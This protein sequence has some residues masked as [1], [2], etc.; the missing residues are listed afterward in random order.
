MIYNLDL[1]A[2]TLSILSSFIKPRLVN[3][4]KSFTFKFFGKLLKLFTSYFGNDCAT[5]NNDLYR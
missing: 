4:F 2:N 5:M 3:T 1:I